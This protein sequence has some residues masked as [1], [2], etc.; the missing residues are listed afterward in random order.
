M[1]FRLAMVTPY[2]EIPGIITGG[3][4]GVSYCLIEGFKRV[5]ELDI[6]VIAPAYHRPE[7]R[8]LRDS[9]TIH[10]LKVGVLPAFVANFSTMRKRVQQ[11]LKDLNPEVTHFQGQASWLPG[12][13]KPCVLT[14]HGIFER[15]LLYRGGAFLSLRRSLISW[16]ECQGRRQAKE[17]ILISPYV[18]EEIGSQLPGRHWDI[19]NPVTQDFFEVNR[20]GNQPRIL[21]VGRIGKRKN[22]DGLLRAF[23]RVRRRVPEAVLHIAG[24]TESSAYADDCRSFV[25]GNGL[26]RSVRFLGNISRDELI[27]ELT[28]ARCLTLVSHQETAP[29]IIEEAM[30]S[31]VPVVASNICGLPYMVDEGRTGFLVSPADEVQIADRLVALLE[32]DVLN[33]HMREQCRAVALERFHTDNV[34]RKTMQVYLSMLAGRNY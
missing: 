18:L 31:G 5:A 27:Q 22:V 14:V 6:H 9:I 32:D 17:I 20:S 1:G 25:S 28:H 10:W 7:G 15:D 24:K 16:S 21:F 29:M 34:A 30:A 11:C 19:E 13:K 23:T 26:D 8:E 12:Y 33:N 3:V 4:E 2:P